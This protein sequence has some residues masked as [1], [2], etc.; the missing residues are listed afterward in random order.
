M[1]KIAS[2]DIIDRDIKPNAPPISP[3]D[4][5]T[6]KFAKPSQSKPI[7]TSIDKYEWD[8]V[9][10]GSLKDA[11]LCVVSYRNAGDSLSESWY[12]LGRSPYPLAD[13]KRIIEFK[14]KMPANLVIKSKDLGQDNAIWKLYRKYGKSLKWQHT[15]KGKKNLFK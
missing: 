4:Y 11:G 8:Q 7:D 3:I 5:Y 12:K 14:D 13:G 10:Y 15:Y 2:T 9:S 1:V 6:R